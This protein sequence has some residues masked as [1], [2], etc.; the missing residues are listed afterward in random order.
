[1]P[2]TSKPRVSVSVV[3]HLPIRAYETYRAAFNDAWREY[4]DRDMRRE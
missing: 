1:M 2:Y 3:R 4:A